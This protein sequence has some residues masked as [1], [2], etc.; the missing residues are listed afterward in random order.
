MQVAKGLGSR[1]LA[2]VADETQATVAHQA[3]AD[4][5]IVLKPGFSAV[6]RQMVERGVDVVVDPLGDWLFDEALRC[7]SPEGRIVV[8]GFAAGEIPKVAVN[9]LLLRNVS[10]VGA[11]WGAFLD[12]EPELVSQQAETLAAM[13]QSR[14]VAPHIDVYAFDD[15]PATLERLGRGAV[16]GKAVVDAG[17]VITI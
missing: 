9:R 1:V 6:I 5:V 12:L 15:L 11:A 13:V 10:V 4:E 14:V 2:G 16:R 8:V 17:P 3:G 7:L